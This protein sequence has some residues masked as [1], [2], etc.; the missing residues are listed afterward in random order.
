[1]FDPSRIL[2]FDA[3]DDPCISESARHDLWVA[4]GRPERYTIHNTHR[5][6]FYSMTILGGNWMQAKVWQFFERTLLGQAPAADEMRHDLADVTLLGAA[7]RRRALH[8]GLS[9]SSP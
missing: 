1:M 8:V 6:A 5:K 3:R 7:S 9:G 4:M 2:I